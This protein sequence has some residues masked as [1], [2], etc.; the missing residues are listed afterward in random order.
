MPAAV[1]A[2][3]SAVGASIGGTTG[4]FLIMNAGAVATASL[5]AASLSVGNYQRRKAKQAARAAF[6]ASL[7]D[8]LVMVST[9]TGAR[10]RCYGRVR[11]VDGVLFKATRGT[12]NEFYTLFIA[13][14]GHEIDGFEDVYFGDQLVTLDGN[15]YVQTSPFAIERKTSQTAGVVL[16]GSGAGTATI[17]GTYVTGSASAVQP[18]TES[19][20]EKQ[21]TVSVSGSTISISGG[22]SGASAIVNWQTSSLESKARVRFYLG[23]PTQDLSVVLDPLFP[24]LIDSTHRFA[25]IAGMLVDLEYDPD[26]WPSGVPSISAVFRG[27]KV[28][29]PRSSP[30]LVWTQNPALIA[31]DWALY[32]YGGGATAA[33][34]DEQSFEDAA[35]ACDVTHGFV[36]PSG[37]Q[38][39]PLYTCGIVCR[40]DTDPWDQ[41]LEIVESMAGKTGW[42]GG[43]LRVVAGE[44]RSPVATITEDWISNQGEIQ[45]VAEPPTEDAVNVY[46]STISDKDQAYVA[47]QAPE[48]RSATYIAADGR[49]LPREV[50]L[51]G[52]TD[53]IHA[54][55]VM[56]VL[57]RDS[58]NGLTAVLPCN[59]RAFQLDL[60]DLVSVTLP[61]FGWSAKTFEIIDW[62]FSAEG[63]VVLT[64]KETAAAIYTPD[65]NFKELDLTPNTDLPD[66]ASVPTPTGLTVSTAVASLDDGQPVVRALVQWNA[67]ADASILQGGFIEIQ[68]FQIGLID[69]PVSWVNNTPAPV[70]WQNNSLSTVSWNSLQQASPTN[71]ALWQSVRVSGIQTSHVIP[72]IK[73]SA[74][75]LFRLRAINAIGVAS[76]YGVQQFVLTAAPPIGASIESWFAQDAAGVMFSNAV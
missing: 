32:K 56:G 63:G 6:N 65:A 36:T 8:R 67:I 4:A 40:T 37:T 41:F 70:T 21:L 29:D 69:L 45:I 59:M 52:V 7:E 61:R 3:V 22:D 25:G 19:T 10:S 60:F 42:G 75:Y 31:R 72:A 48:I 43:T 49:E 39:L 74:S 33:D 24:S 76:Q 68:Y 66:P 9:A 17:V 62:A 51:A 15:G 13:V 57:M 54:Q 44:Y 30:S 5:V 53:V 2:V 64:L 12:N 20:D 1:T 55:H 27:A 73:A 28:E 46:R 16:N 11:N 26:A 23:T 71:A 34:I 18:A 14:A 50:A 58:R 38:T 35:N 47:V